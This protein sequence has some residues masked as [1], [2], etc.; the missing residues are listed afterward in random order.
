MREIKKVLV[1]GAGVMGHG[2]A[3]VF[4][5][6]GLEVYLI[7]RDKDVLDRGLKWIRENLESLVELERL[8]A[9]EIEKI[10]GRVKPGLD[11]R[12]VVSEV[13]YVLEAVTENLELKKEV[14]VSLGRLTGPEVILATNTSSYDINEFCNVAAHPERVIGTHWFHPPQITPCVEIIPG[15]ATG[16][17]TIERATDLMKKIGKFPTR[18]QSGP[19]FVANRIQNAMAAE[20]LKLVEEGLATPEEVDRVVKSSFGF[21]L[22]AYG[23]FEIIDQAGADTYL[24]VFEYLYSKLKR[25]HFKPSPLLARLVEEGRL[26]LKAGAG[27]YEYK[28]GAAESLKR[29]RDSRLWARHSLFWKEQE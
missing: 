5:A 1:L 23:P 8:E 4:A 7:D 3:Q 9:E 28:N 15:G 14:F 12:P 27:F 2:F 19:G 21:R 6:N 25:D 20:A 26:G 13:D 10:L 18:V 29:E 22:S 24:S 16:E 17:E 11:Y